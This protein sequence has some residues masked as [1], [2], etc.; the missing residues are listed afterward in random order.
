MISVVSCLLMMVFARGM[1]KFFKG[2]KMYKRT[3][4]YWTTTSNALNMPLLGRS[5]WTRN[6]NNDYNYDNNSGT[7]DDE[8]DIKHDH[9]DDEKDTYTDPNYSNTDAQYDGNYNKQQFN[10][11]SNMIMDSNSNA[12]SIEM[13]HIMGK[14]G[15]QFNI[16]MN[17]N[18]NRFQSKDQLIVHSNSVSTNASDYEVFKM[19]KNDITN[20]IS[21]LNNT[22]SNA[23]GLQTV[24]AYSFNNNNNW[25]NTS[26]T[27]NTSTASNTISAH[28][29]SNS[30]SIAHSHGHVY[31]P[32]QFESEGEHDH[33][34]ISEMYKS[35]GNIT[36]YSSMH[37]HQEGEVHHRHGSQKMS[38]NCKF[39]YNSQR[40]ACT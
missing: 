40:C 2:K 36:K 20:A 14:P 9:D 12:N 16:N 6:K 39:Q 29:H 23:N 11:Q 3:Q 18:Y 34:T 19:S 26:N 33:D 22:N 7:R 27:S 4:S 8:S 10:L 15:N 31:G 38:V 17:S 13:S 21:N 28:V 1:W 30:N 24:P 5:H 37:H 32:N 35:D 25:I